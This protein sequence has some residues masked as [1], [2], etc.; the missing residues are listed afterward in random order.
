MNAAAKGT[1]DVVVKS[2]IEQV[3]C[4]NWQANIECL[5]R[6]SDVDAALPGA[7]GACSG[8]DPCG[9]RWRRGDANSPAVDRD[10]HHDDYGRFR[11]FRCLSKEQQ[12]VIPNASSKL[13]LQSQPGCLL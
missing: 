4:E 10:P 13:A 3:Y 7:G 9:T 1:G 2:Q 12:T 11:A 6:S 5:R 8:A